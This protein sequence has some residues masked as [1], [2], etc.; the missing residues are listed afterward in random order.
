[1]RAITKWL[2]MAVCMWKLDDMSYA[3][4]RDTGWIGLLLHGF[5]I[6]F[7]MLAFPF[8]MLIDFGK[9]DEDK[10]AWTHD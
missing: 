7:P 9:R 6:V 2:I 10:D 5:L 1:M 3:I 8:A 4:L